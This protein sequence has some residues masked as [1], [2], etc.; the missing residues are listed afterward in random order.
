MNDEYSELNDIILNRHDKSGTRKKMLI[1][2][3]TLAIVAI[4]IVFIMGRMSGSAPSQLPQPMPA[5]AQP[6]AS[7]SS[8]QPEAAPASLVATSEAVQETEED[9]QDIEESSVPQTPVPLAQ[10]EVTVIDETTETPAVPEKAAVTK[11]SAPETVVKPVPAKPAPVTYTAPKPKPVVSGT[12]YIQIGSFSRYEPSKTF[13]A[14]VERNG[15]TYTFDRVVLNG[16]IV[17]KVLIGPFK[18]RDDAVAKLPDV[19]RKIESGAFIY[20]KK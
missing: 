3:G 7:V 1:G 5:V 6:E 4:L 8:V 13:L 12:V 14:N 2:I 19:R 17:N 18:N 16:Q 10:S 20:T 9:D 11:P 15:Y